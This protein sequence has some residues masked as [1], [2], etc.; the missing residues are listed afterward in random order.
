MMMDGVWISEEAEEPSQEVAPLAVA[1]GGRQLERRPSTAR[2]T[3]TGPTSPPGI[4]TSS[5]PLAASHNTM[6][7]AP[8]SLILL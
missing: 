8:A 3:G 6:K 7:E 2:A 4:S 5:Y 1:E